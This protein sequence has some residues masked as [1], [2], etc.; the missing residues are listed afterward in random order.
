MLAYAIV[1]VSLFLFVQ[2]ENVYPQLL[3]A[4]LLFSLG[5]AGLSTMIT[6]ILPA[7]AGLR[8]QQDLADDQSFEPGP[9]V[10]SPPILEGS[11]AQLTKDGRKPVTQSTTT[12]SAGFVGLFSGCG[13]L[14]ALLVYLHLPNA[15]ESAGASPEN[16]LANSYRIVGALAVC[17]AAICVFG[18][19]GMS[20][21]RETNRI[22]LAENAPARAAWTSS[23]VPWNLVEA[24]KLAFSMR[25]LGLAYIGGFVARSS[26]VGI[27]LF[28][29]L[30]VNAY[31]ISTGLCDDSGSNPTDVKDKCRE[32]YTLAAEL[33]GVSQLFA[34]V[35]APCF[36]FLAE[37]Y[38]RF[39]I[40]LLVAALVGVIGYFNLANLRSP[41]TSGENGSPLIF[42][43]MGL[44]GISQIGAIVCSLGLL[45]RCVQGVLENRESPHPAA[46][47]P[48]PP[49]ATSDEPS[50]PY[51]PDDIT[52][53][54]EHTTLLREENHIRNHEHLKGSIAGIYSFC[55]G[56]GILI[57]TK[58][59]GYLFDTNPSAPFLLLGSFNAL[60][61]LLGLI[62][63]VFDLRRT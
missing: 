57:L 38:R 56:V 12:R 58:L 7:I 6:A 46:Q 53:P 16:A 31:F 43:L 1:G 25:Q 40:C 14:I 33:T 55:G 18:F 35:F 2:V 50:Y 26:S 44:I 39:N 20:E 13:A 22:G 15:F 48:S 11:S 45:G 49:S 24:V 54:Q 52:P 3:L 8:A 62:C 36:G 47:D 59:G 19:R 28:M 29:P 23:L 63:A 61:L 37:R 21:D 17:L 27:T 30:F 60:L 51:M 10:F 34:L 32:A 9:R 4:R 5:A 41:E 42:V